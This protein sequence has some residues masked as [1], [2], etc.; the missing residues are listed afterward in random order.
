MKRKNVVTSTEGCIRF[1][2]DFS[3]ML[4]RVI[5]EQDKE[6]IEFVKQFAIFF[7]KKGFVFNSSSNLEDQVLAFSGR[8]QADGCEIPR[9]NIR[10]ESGM[11]PVCFWT[12]TDSQRVNRHFSEL[13]Q[14]RDP[15]EW[16]GRMYAEYMQR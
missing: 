16:F 5:S 10:F 8:S 11:Q 9:I 15:S 6:R 12:K 4:K 2:D 13:D 1:T 7:I 14:K 3:S